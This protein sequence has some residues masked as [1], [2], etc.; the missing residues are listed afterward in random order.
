MFTA[1]HVTINQHQRTY[2]DYC[3]CTSNK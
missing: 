2:S 3:G 1:R